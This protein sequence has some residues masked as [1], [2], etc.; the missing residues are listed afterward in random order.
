[1][2]IVIINIIFAIST[3]M[4]A[5]YVYL[6]IS[7]KRWEHVAGKVLTISIQ[8]NSHP[9]K[10]IGAPPFE[11]TCAPNIKYEY[12]VNGKKY[13]GTKLRFGVINREYENESV[14]YDD[15]GFSEGDNIDVYYYKRMPK[16]SVIKPNDSEITIYIMLIVF[17]LAGIFAVTYFY[18]NAL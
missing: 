3:V 5:T 14:M 18:Y 15:L 11:I 13:I 12:I 4:L 9:N 2:L 16:I 6:A 10:R 7:S 17:S 1:M 8:K